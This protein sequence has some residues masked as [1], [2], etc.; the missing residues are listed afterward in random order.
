MANGIVSICNIGL[1]AL[2]EDPIADMD[3]PYK[4][5]ILMKASYDRVRRE[6][7]EAFPW[8]CAKKQARL[9]ASVSNKPVF[10]WDNA[11]ELPADFVRMFQEQNAS[12]PQWE[13][14]GNLIFANTAAP[15]DC[16]YVCDLDDTT[17]MS[18]LLRRMIGLTLASELCEPFTQSTEKQR[19]IDAKLEAARAMAVTSSSQQASSEAWDIDVLLEARA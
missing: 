3:E 6:V 11:F 15:F 14:V 9:A 5:A 8:R 4:T 13:V 7:L 2:G 17:K 16:V 1:I 18:P 12:E 10:G 19:K